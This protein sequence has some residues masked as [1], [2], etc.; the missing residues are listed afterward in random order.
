MGTRSGDVD[1]G[2]L[3]YVMERSGLSA[4][5]MSRELNQRSGL[6]GLSG[7]SADMRELLERERH[8]DTDAALAIEVFCQRARHYLAAYVTELGGVDAIVFGGGI[9]ENAPEIRRRIIEGFQWAGIA[10]DLEANKASVGIEVNIAA[11]DSRSALYSIP[12]D[13][14]RVIAAEAASLLAQ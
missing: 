14:A 13:E 2:A 5:D 1:A 9:G 6:L 11:R 4:A 10:L 12:V 8:G 7:R 3:L